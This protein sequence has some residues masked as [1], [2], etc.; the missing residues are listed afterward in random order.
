[1][2]LALTKLYW[3]GRLNSLKTATPSSLGERLNAVRHFFTYSKTKQQRTLI[4]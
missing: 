1:M 2:V 4:L 3:A